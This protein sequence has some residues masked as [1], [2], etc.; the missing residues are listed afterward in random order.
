[1]NIKKVKIKIYS[2]NEDVSSIN[3]GL[4]QIELESVPVAFTSAKT[5]VPEEDTII[6]LQID[7]LD[8]RLLA[9]IAPVKKDIPNKFIVVIKG[10][11]S[12]LVSSIVKMGF[13]DVFVFP[14]GKY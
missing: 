13:Y 5:F 1:M 10:N 9:E 2:D 6:I 4:R 11:N 7:S 8:S 3:S 12:L 14:Y